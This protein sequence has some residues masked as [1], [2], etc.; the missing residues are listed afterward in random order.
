M[1]AGAGDSPEARRRNA[2][3]REAR[4]GRLGPWTR[5]DKRRVEKILRKEVVKT[6]TG[7]KITVNLDRREKRAA[8]RKFGIS[9]KRCRERER[10]E[11]QGSRRN[12]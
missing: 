7:A 11:R 6:K 8:Q 2:A 9:G 1:S 5:A 12:R 4:R 10:N 3:Q